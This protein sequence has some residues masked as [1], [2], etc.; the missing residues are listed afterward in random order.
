M[1][2]DLLR[3]SINSELKTDRTKCM[4]DA[5]APTVTKHSFV[6][7]VSAEEAMSDIH[8]DSLGSLS[9]LIRVVSRKTGG[10]L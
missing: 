5:V 3:A 2:P 7:W 4:K 1:Y 8:L 10:P 6:G 9:S